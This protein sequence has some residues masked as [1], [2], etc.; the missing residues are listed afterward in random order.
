LR[1][2]R[3]HGDSGN[4]PCVT[5]RKE[6]TMNQLRGITVVMGLCVLLAP[7]SAWAEGSLFVGRWHW[8]RVQSTLP[9]G[10][11]VPKDLICDI[12][13]ADN[14]HVKWPITILTTEGQPQV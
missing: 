5:K 4:P 8:N 7:C 1:C 12:A 14:S 10:A 3:L 9:P 2:L 6:D 11:P 13:R